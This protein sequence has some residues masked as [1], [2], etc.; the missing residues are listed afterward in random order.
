MIDC[1]YN[2]AKHITL[3]IINNNVYLIIKAPLLAEDIQRRC[4]VIPEI[5]CMEKPIK[6]FERQTLFICKAF[7]SRCLFIIDLNFQETTH[8]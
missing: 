3:I 7:L 6:C 5:I 1:C 8:F 4:T 2:F